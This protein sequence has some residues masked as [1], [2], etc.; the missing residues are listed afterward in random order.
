MDCTKDGRFLLMVV[1][2]DR[3]QFKGYRYVLSF[4]FGEMF[5][6]VSSRKLED[7]SPEF[8]P[9]LRRFRDLD[10][11]GSVF[12]LNLGDK[13]EIIKVTRKGEISLITVLN[14]SKK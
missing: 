14:D 9:K 12:S 8:I 2:T 4:K 13:I 11:R 6:L 5:E 3:D 10:K 1:S 7:F